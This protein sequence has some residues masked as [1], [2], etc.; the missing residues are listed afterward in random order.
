MTCGEQSERFVSFLR[1]RCDG[2]AARASLGR[3]LLGW[4]ARRDLRYHAGFHRVWLAWREALPDTAAHCRRSFWSSVDADG[5][6]VRGA[7]PDLSLHHRLHGCGRLLPRQP[8]TAPVSRP[9]R[10]LRV[11]LWRTGFPVHVFCC[12]ATLCA[13]ARSL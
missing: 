4:T 8:D 5:M 1:W 3:D 9:R 13:R 12:T 10:S 2:I 6:D 11:D 7:R